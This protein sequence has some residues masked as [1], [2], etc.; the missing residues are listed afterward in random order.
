MPKRIG[1]LAILLLA[2]IGLFYGAIKCGSPKSN[3]RALRHG[4]CSQTIQAEW[5][6]GLVFQLGNGC[7]HQHPGL[8]T[9]KHLR[10][11]CKNWAKYYDEDAIGYVA[12]TITKTL[13]IVVL[14]LN[15]KNHLDKY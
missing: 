2:G 11:P 13:R 14:V 6:N 15:P 1:L 9:G 5:D 3:L 8:R 10:R 4:Q 7:I 12:K